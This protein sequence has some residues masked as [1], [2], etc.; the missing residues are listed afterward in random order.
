[1]ITKT[2]TLDLDHYARTLCPTVVGKNAS[3]WQVKAEVLED[4]YEW[5]NHFEAFHPLYGIVYGDFEDAVTA[6]SEAAL[7]HF[8]SA[9]PVEDWD[10]WD[11]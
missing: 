10:Y 3:G 9:H 6:S 2:Y 5:V 11:I 4:Y 7:Q 8:L 1:M